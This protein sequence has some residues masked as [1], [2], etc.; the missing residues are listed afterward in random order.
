MAAVLNHIEKGTVTLGGANA[1][2]TVT[3]GT[4]LTSTAAAF[5]LHSARH[6]DASPNKV[7]FRGEITN[8]TTLTFTRDASGD[9]ITI[10]WQV[11]EFTSGVTVQRGVVNGDGVNS[12]FNVTISA[13]VL[14]QTFC[15]V[16][17]ETDGSSVGDDDFIS[18]NLTSTTNLR[19]SADEGATPK[20]LTNQKF[21]SWQVIEFTDAADISVVRGSVS[22]GVGDTSLDATGL[23]ACVVAKT[24]LLVSYNSDNTAA[25]NQ[26]RY[27]I[28]GSITSTTALNFARV[29]SGMT[30]V[31]YWERVE[32]L[33]DTTVQ[34]IAISMADAVATDNETI[35]A[36]T[37]AS[38]FVVSSGDEGY[39]GDS[40]YTA[41]DIL[42]VAR[43]ALELTTTTN[44]LATRDSAN[45]ITTAVVYVVDWAESAASDQT[46]TAPTVSLALSVN[47]PTLA[48]SGAAPITGT[49]VSLALSVQAPVAS[50]SGTATA[51]APT[52]TAVAFAV[53]APSLAPSGAAPITPTP[54]SLALSVAAPTIAGS[55]TAAITAPTVTL[56]LSVAEPTASGSGTAPA[57]APTPTDLAFA[58]NAPSVAAGGAAP[59]A[60]TP[61]SLALAVNAPTLA[62]SGTASITAPTVAMALTVNAPSV[63]GSGTATVGPPAPVELAF[64]VNEPTQVAT[65]GGAQTITM[66]GAVALALSVN[67]PAVAGSGAAA[68]TAPSVGLAL[69]VNAP[70]L[71]GSGSAPATLAPVGM[72]LSVNA[73][74]LAGSGSAPVTAP[75][76]SMAFSVVAPAL[77]ATGAAPVA[78]AP[79]VLAM[80]VAAPALSGSGTATAITVG[81]V[82]LVLSVNA[83]STFAGTFG[84]PVPGPTKAVVVNPYNGLATYNQGRNSLTTSHDGGNDAVPTHDGANEALCYTAGINAAEVTE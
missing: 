15:T 11:I 37:L 62:G 17:H 45:G 63:A 46:I 69:T 5:L 78:P 74:S 66:T 51:I 14:A 6:N 52:P 77:A 48:A 68:V 4:T 70:A 60:A 40:T 56:A 9:E 54:V 28:K 32:F 22:F 50:G 7:Q 73:P 31:L 27:N 30:M 81:V 72:A 19:L 42:G 23:A 33:N 76:I 82:L 35:T 44:L 34:A 67:A 13:I 57:I 21:M 18:C 65:S 75:A 24:M 71:A 29:S 83:P 47:A 41:N 36:V 80:S 3:L 61:V 84:I 53:N 26:D 2:V 39:A 64:S 16:G 25:A 55:G 10:N 59:I 38:A 49:T 79:T 20:I 1:S 12:E 58:V 43:Y 8:T